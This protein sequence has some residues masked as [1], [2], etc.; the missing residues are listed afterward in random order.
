[1]KQFKEEMLEKMRYV[2]KK[3]GLTYNGLLGERFELNGRK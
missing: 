3:K 1:M 2:S